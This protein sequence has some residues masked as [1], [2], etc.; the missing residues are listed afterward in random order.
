MKKKEVHSKER[1]KG[2]LTWGRRENH[3][4]ALFH[5]KG[6]SIRW[7]NRST[8]REREYIFKIGKRIFACKYYCS[9]YRKEE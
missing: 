6:S 7:G 3:S 4:N 5:G 8:L 2:S 1:K 9:L